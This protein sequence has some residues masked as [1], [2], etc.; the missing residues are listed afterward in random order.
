M[1]EASSERADML[2][3]MGS[4]RG[5]MSPR[6]MRGEESGADKRAE[7]RKA[8]REELDG[9]KR[10]EQDGDKRGERGEEDQ[11]SSPLEQCVTRIRQHVGADRFEA[12]L[13]LLEGFVFKYNLIRSTAPTLLAMGP[14]A[15]DLLKLL[16]FTEM[17]Q[18]YLSVGVGQRDALE[19]G[20]QEF[21]R[22]QNSY[23]L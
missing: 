3:A 4:S 21:H 10:G 8:L 12:T 20:R 17:R 22:L 7:Q 18:G 16:G 23:K 15:L 1:Q 13:Q 5:L 2:R 19:K 9:D 6:M 14:G 11:E